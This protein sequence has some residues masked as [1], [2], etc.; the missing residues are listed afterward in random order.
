MNMLHLATA[1]DTEKLIALIARYH[2]FEGLETTDEQRRA[3]LDTLFSGEVQTA[4][5]LIG[6][7]KSPVG[8]IAIS[9]G[10]SIRLGGR[11]AFID[12]F[13]IRDSVRGRGM[14][15]QTL[16]TIVPLLRQLGI[17]SLHMEIPQN[18]SGARRLYERAGFQSR[19]EYRSMTQ[20]L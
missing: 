5:W 4:I 8:Y 13:F 10:F 12:E 7:R 11:N 17:C 6:P 3:A 20:V 2:A 18:N 1:G 16:A 15:S 9:F 19:D 14:G